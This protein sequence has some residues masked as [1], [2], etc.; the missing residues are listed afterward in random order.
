MLPGRH[1]AIAAGPLPLPV[2]PWHEAQLTCATFLPCSTTLG[3]A[4]TALLRCFSESGAVQGVW[5][6]TPLANSRHPRL[7]ATTNA[8]RGSGDTIDLLLQPSPRSRGE[9]VR[10]AS[11]V[12]A[13]P[14]RA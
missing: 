6:R 9:G 1:G 7:T 5:A 14:V 10:V 8:R 12:P 11:L 13:R 4:A 3:P 2:F